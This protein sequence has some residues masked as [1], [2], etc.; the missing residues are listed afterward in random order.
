M[1]EELLT[2]L[3]AAVE[4]AVDALDARLLFLRLVLI[5]KNR[6]VAHLGLHLPII[7]IARRVERALFERLSHGA[8]RLALVPTVAEAALCRDRFDVLERL[9]QTLLA[10]EQ[11]KLAHARRVEDE[12]AA[13][14]HQRPAVRRRVPPA[15]VTQTNF[16]RALNL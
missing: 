6:G 12:S 15:H 13:R 7:L 14:E 4:C 2:S 11:L 10:H 3:L 9:A 16:L 1:G 8:A 5:L